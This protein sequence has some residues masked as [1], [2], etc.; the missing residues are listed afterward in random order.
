MGVLSALP[1]VSAG[2]YC[3][4]LWVISGGL[5]A[6]YV[7]LCHLTRVTCGP[8]AWPSRWAVALFAFA[9]GMGSTLFFLGARAY[10]YHEAILC[11]AAFA[12]WS[13]YFSLRWLDAPARRGW[14]PGALVCGVAAVHAR[15]PAG[16]FA[17]AVLDC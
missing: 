11:G 14:W 16:L 15:P 9:V 5:V 1:I 13:A 8:P 7:L 10:I 3:C 4:C 17:L 6:A 2:N 12:L